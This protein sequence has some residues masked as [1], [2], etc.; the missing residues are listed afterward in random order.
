MNAEVSTSEATA[1]QADFSRFTSSAGSRRVAR[2]PDL[3]RG[4]RLLV[5]KH[6][7]KAARVA[8]QRARVLRQEGSH[9]TAKIWEEIAEILR[10]QFDQD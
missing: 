7:R 9:D 3:V 5:Q 4:A 6:G 2:D 1:P 10:E 8:E